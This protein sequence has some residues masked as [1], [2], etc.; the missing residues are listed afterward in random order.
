MYLGAFK[1][2]MPGQRFSYLAMAT[3][4]INCS[5]HLL[6]SPPPK[7]HRIRSPQLF[8]CREAGVQPRSCR[9]SL[10]VHLLTASC[11]AAQNQ[12][13]NPGP[14]GEPG[15]HG[16]SNAGKLAVCCLSPGPS[17]CYTWF[18]SFISTRT[19][20]GENPSPERGNY[21]IKVTQKCASTSIR[22]LL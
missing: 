10:R 20:R 22:T 14:A 4:A 13:C 3:T 18:I 9:P 5:V 8:L 1:T 21:T 2:V 16:Q 11:Q 17:T 12:A 7:S 19:T 6:S 15:A